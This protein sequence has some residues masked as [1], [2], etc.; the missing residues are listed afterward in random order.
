MGRTPKPY[1]SL[2]LL[3]LIQVLRT[4]LKFFNKRHFEPQAPQIYSFFEMPD[5]DP[6]PF[7]ITETPER[8]PREKVEKTTTKNHL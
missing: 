5:S 4:V 3:K 7:K 1:S 2:R 8:I 6:V